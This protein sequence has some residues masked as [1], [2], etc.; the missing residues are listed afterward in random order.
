MEFSNAYDDSQRAKAYAQLQ[1][2]GTYYLAFRDLP[3]LI[4]KHVSGAAAMDVG[5]GA[6]RSTRFLQSLGFKTIGVDISEAML[7]Q[8]VEFDPQGDYRLLG[9]S[10][11][12]S[13]SDRAF[14]LILSAFTFDNVPTREQKVGIMSELARLLR[15]TGRFVNLVSSPEIYYHE[16]AS[17][18][19]R[20]FPQNRMAKPGEIVKIINTDIDDA[21]PVD[22]V[23]WP[24][25]NYLDVYGKAGL[26]LIDIHRPLGSED[27]PFGWINETRIAPWV[28]YLLGV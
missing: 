4:S 14:D 20:D 3:S 13:F 19:T 17:F 7:K 12:E 1:F 6:G 18:S 23:L 21:R 22:D 9:D 2:P 10:G 28:I 15:P 25:E 27:E 11:F 24:H 5:C 8:A 16:W 26:R